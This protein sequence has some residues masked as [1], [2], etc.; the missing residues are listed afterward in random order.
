[1]Q[2][3][4]LPDANQA[5]YRLISTDGKY[6][7]LRFGGPEQE[8]IEGVIVCQAL[9]GHIKHKPFEPSSSIAYIKWDS[10]IDIVQ[11]TM[12]HGIFIQP[13][14]DC[15]RVE[16]DLYLLQDNKILEIGSFDMSDEVA[17]RSIWAFDNSHSSLTSTTNPTT[18]VAKL[19]ADQR[20]V[21]G[22]MIRVGNSIHAVLVCKMTETMRVER[23]TKIPDPNVDGWHKDRRS[24]CTG[25]IDLFPTNLLYK[26]D[27][28]KGET[29][30]ADSGTWEII[31]A[32]GGTVNDNEGLAGGEA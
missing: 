16:T 10:L 2:P 27:R 22:L 21:L 5:A 11:D 15:V 1:M 12:R 24:F 6:I 3:K 25:Q 30:Q 13:S 28:K 19:W 8:A 17:Y 14:Y 4:G 9:A 18:I 26:S 7:E 23:W 31:E 29:H 32:S 20:E